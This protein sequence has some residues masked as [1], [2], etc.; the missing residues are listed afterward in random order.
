MIHLF[1]NRIM[2]LDEVVNETE[3]FH[4][5]ELRGLLTAE[6]AIPLKSFNKNASYF[7]SPDVDDPG[8]YLLYKIVGSAVQ[9]KNI[10]LTGVHKFF[11][12][13]KGRRIKEKGPLTT[14][15][16]NAMVIALD[17][18]GWTVGS[19][20]VIGDR[21][22]NY[23]YLSSLEAFNMNLDAWGCDYELKM[24][25]LNG[26]ITSQRVNFYTQLGTDFGKWY[27]YGD[28]KLVEIVKEDD[29]N[30]FT[31]YIGR[32]SSLPVT[33]ADN[34]LTGGY[35]RKL[36]F[37]DM[38]WTAPTNPV[39]KPAGQD[40]VEIPSATA[41][42]GYPDGSPKIGIVE[43]EEEDPA[44]LLQ[45]TYEYTL[46]NARPKVQLKSTVRENENVILGEI[47]TIIRD[48]IGIRYK[49]RVFKLKRNF[50][51]K[52]MKEFEFGDKLVESKAQIIKALE[53]ENYEIRKETNSKLKDALDAITKSYFN[54]DG[55]NYELKVGNQYNL[56]AGYYSFNA[57]ID[58][59]PTKV[60]YMGAGKI[61]IANSK[62]PDGTWKW[63]TAADGDGIYGSVI[64]ANSIT[65]NKLAAD[66]GQSL[67]L[68]SNVS[69]TSTVRSEVTTQLNDP[70]TQEKFRGQDAISV[71]IISTN[72]L[73]F[74]NDEIQTTL[75]ARVYKGDK[76]ITD[77]ID[78]ARFRWTNVN[79]DGTKDTAWNTA[80]FGGA[81]QVTVTG[82]D[83]L[84][85][86]TFNC[87]ILEG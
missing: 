29:V 38:V 40:Y 22:I 73:V 4:E 20:D 35:T 23:Y 58:Q 36:T 8:N 59:N 67:D 30:I 11:D 51:K 37:S 62:D 17:K 80:H 86:A 16:A 18:T 27:E 69:I 75:I 15:L 61:L 71:D 46:E 33:D 9:G 66:V 48:D 53:K 72:G 13:L 45:R 81:K 2:L 26:K 54:D 44:K 55:Y 43:F 57:P 65:A 7:G 25:F 63:T 85:R 87:E 1:D 32:G 77:T 10:I 74:K 42:Y 76:D 82:E 14:T 6:V 83:I 70:A 50:L 84:N 34:H 21:H 5:A 64:I 24:T 12:D 41:L 79:A 49:A 52:G 78:A 39:S 28:R 68:S 3:N 31:A 60:V 47:C 56:P 19:S